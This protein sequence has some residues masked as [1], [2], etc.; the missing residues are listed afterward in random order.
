MTGLSAL[1][2]LMMFA[3]G[4]DHEVEPPVS[5]IHYYNE[6]TSTYDIYCENI[7]PDYYSIEL[8]FEK[9]QGLRPSTPFPLRKTIE[10]GRHLL[11]RLSRRELHVEGKFKV[12]LTYRRGFIDYDLQDNFPYLLPLKNGTVAELFCQDSLLSFYPGKTDSCF[13]VNGFNAY[14]SDTIYASRR[15]VV[16]KLR[17]L[18][19]D[20][21]L[22][23]SSIGYYLDIQHADGTYG[24][25]DG[26][27]VD[28]PMIVSYGQVVEAGD[29]IAVVRETTAD[30]TFFSYQ[31][32]Y[33]DDRV[34]TDPIG[35][36]NVKVVSVPIQFHNEKLNSCAHCYEVEHPEAIITMEMNKRELRKWMRKTGKK[37][38][39]PSFINREK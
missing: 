3:F 8:D 5:V 37:G 6:K 2:G 29:P 25:Y 27:Q 20:T 24:R 7:G 26:I 17:H 31:V 32:F 16:S 30:S 11:M 34:V 23:H 35:P 15:G 19:V 21:S 14:P 18:A 13:H 12:K 9:L 22:H 28:S 39:L 4:A 1:I 38:I 10:P 33:Y 36:M